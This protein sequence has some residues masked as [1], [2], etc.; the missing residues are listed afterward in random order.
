MDLTQVLRAFGG[1]LLFF[2]P[3]LLLT[4]LFFRG[5]HVSLLER[6]PLSFVLSICIITVALFA[7]NKLFDI[8]IS[9]ATSIVVTIIISLAIVVALMRA[10]A[11]GRLSFPGHIEISRR[12][13]MEYIGLAAILAW[14]F[15]MAFIPHL[16]YSYP[17]HVDEWSAFGQSQALTQAQSI[18]YTDPFYGEATVSDH[19]EIGFRLFLSEMKL[20]TGLSWV[21]IFLVFPG[22]IFMLAVLVSYAIGRRAN[23]GLEAA[24]FVALIPTTVRFLGPSFLVPVAVGLLFLAMI[25]FLLHHFE[26]N[27]T[28]AFILLL[29]LGFLF[30]CHPITAV[31]AT[32][33]CFIYGFTILWESEERGIRRW[34]SP[35]LIWGAVL[36]PAS[37]GLTRNW[38]AI[39]G[40]LTG[41]GEPGSRGLPLLSD[42][43][44][45]FGLIP[46][47]LFAAGVGFLALVG[48]KKSWGLL[49]SSLAFL[50]IVFM[51]NW[52]NVKR[53]PSFYDRSFIYLFLLAGTIAGFAL[54]NLRL[55]L[56]GFL[57]RFTRKAFL[58]S[59]LL[60]LALV[61]A[62]GSL[63]VS[64]RFDVPY[65]RLITESQYHDCL[66]IRENLDSSY[67]KAVVNPH[68]AIA[69]SPL[70]GKSVYASNAAQLF[71]ASRIKEVQTFFEGNASDTSWLIKRGIDIVYTDLP[72]DNPDLEEVRQGIYIVPKE[73]QP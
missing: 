64:S 6:I 69:F 40:T 34:Q 9:L 19:Y 38:E 72:V 11:F 8:K 17:I 67:Q 68:I 60:A 46:L 30:L 54:K 10:R 4:L 31:A 52:L 21:N 20:F 5:K 58:V 56:S 41:L 12:Q 51:F 13:L 63:S 28:K 23:Y 26:M 43:L 32:I 37:L 66:W 15:F 22:I 18:T 61:I 16:G 59:L 49:L 44:L 2:L 24:F 29:L 35:L 73:L 14:A 42:A 50:L 7:L 53:V 33:V 48:G 57:G 70:T 55:W 25:V 36:V 65:Y 39:T 3:G 45:E 62:A 1:M 71:S 47:A 27:A